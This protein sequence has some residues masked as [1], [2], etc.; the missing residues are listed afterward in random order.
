MIP[1]GKWGADM[2]A[3]DF[4]SIAHML[5]ADTVIR[6]SRA[7]R[8]VLG[9]EP[10]R[11]AEAGLDLATDRTASFKADPPAAQQASDTSAGTAI[12]AVF[13]VL[14]VLAASV[15]VTGF[16]SA[17]VLVGLFGIPYAA[18]LLVYPAIVTLSGF[19][20]ALPSLAAF[21]RLPK[22]RLP[23]FLGGLIG[24]I[25]TLPAT[26]YLAKWG[27]E[28]FGL[29]LPGAAKN[30]AYI[31]WNVHMALDLRSVP[32]WMQQATPFISFGG[33]ILGTFATTRAKNK[34][35]REREEADA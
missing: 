16:V 12:A 23:I 35:A 20:R 6:D 27:V 28:G 26:Y 11:R 32:T 22:D 15:L 9:F 8:A 30:G 4:D 24:A 19:L 10:M 31:A 13:V 2:I 34:A 21:A 17:A 25:L 18:F 3:A 5:G 1:P 7:A 29:F 14:A 33:A